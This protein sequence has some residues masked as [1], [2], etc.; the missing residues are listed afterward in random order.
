MVKMESASR[1]VYNLNTIEVEILQD[2][3][4]TTIVLWL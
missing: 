1:T 2:N 4:Q 3:Y